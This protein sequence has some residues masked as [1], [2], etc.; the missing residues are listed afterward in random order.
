MCIIHLNGKS[1][2]KSPN[3][4]PLSIEEMI[5]IAA[6]GDIIYNDDTPA[7][8]LENIFAD[9]KNRSPRKVTFTSGFASVKG[10]TKIALFYTGNQHAGENLADLLAKRNRELNPSIQMCPTIGVHI[11]LT[12][13]RAFLKDVEYV[14]KVLRLSLRK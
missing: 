14:L 9:D 6:Q 7:K 5:K 4:L 1:S 12:I 8:I 10:G 13:M 2:R 3:K 11:T